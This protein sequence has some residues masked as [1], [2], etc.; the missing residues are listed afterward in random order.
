MAFATT[1]DMTTR[2]DHRTLGRLLS[3]DGNK[4][5]LVEFGANPVMTMALNDASAAILAILTVGQR[6]N[7][8]DLSSAQSVAGVHYLTRI[9]CEIAF[10]YLWMRRDMTRASEKESKGD[11]RH[12]AVLESAEKHLEDLRTGKHV[13]TIPENQEA[14]RA[15]TAPL[16]VSR[17]EN[18]WDLL[19]DR[20]GNVPN[21]RG[22]RR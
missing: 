15:D 19:R 17:I 1:A 14:G 12:T 21:R 13:L 9:C 6:Y 5:P 22:L 8:D 20:L 4:V 16:S 11:N 2:F 10:S 18:T 7:E 3:S